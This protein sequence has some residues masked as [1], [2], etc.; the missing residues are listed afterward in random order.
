MGTEKTTDS[1]TSV[2]QC[3]CGCG[4]DFA[5]LVSSYN[6][7]HNAKP[8]E[9][10]YHDISTGLSKT[11]G[12]AKRRE[13]HVVCGRTQRKHIL[14]FGSVRRDVCE[15]VSRAQCELS[16]SQVAALTPLSAG[17]HRCGNS[18]RSLGVVAEGTKKDSDFEHR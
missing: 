13:V 15:R 2:T 10:L 9:T 14:S 12:S 18:K 8:I 11:S 4:E 5:D 17:M 1:T 3:V 7:V 6:R 16:L